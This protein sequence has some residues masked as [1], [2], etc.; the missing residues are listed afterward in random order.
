[1]DACDQR[2]RHC[3]W[4]MEFDGVRGHESVSLLPIAV[5]NRGAARVGKSLQMI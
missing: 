3:E 5:L 1:M 4:P 2:T